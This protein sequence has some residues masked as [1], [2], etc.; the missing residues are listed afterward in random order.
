MGIN[1]WIHYMSGFTYVIR[2][3]QRGGEVASIEMQILRFI[4]TVRCQVTDT[5]TSNYFDL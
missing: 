4:Y 1:I 2:I 5:S 3:R